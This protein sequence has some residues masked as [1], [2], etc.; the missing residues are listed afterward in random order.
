ML[1]DYLTHKEK[2]L[3]FEPQ[4]KGIFMCMGYSG[5]CFMTFR[6]YDHIYESMYIWWN[7]SLLIEFFLDPH[8][9]LT[10][11]FYTTTFTQVIKNTQLK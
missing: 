11:L 5:S 2:K 1:I 8:F 9:L 6:F 4:F 3:F 10:C 7:L